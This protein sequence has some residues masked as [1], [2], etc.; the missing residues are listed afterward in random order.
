MIALSRIIRVGAVLTRAWGAHVER[1]RVESL[2]AARR[3]IHHHARARIVM[4]RRPEHSLIYDLEL[5]SLRDE[6]G[7]DH[8]REALALKEVDC[9]LFIPT[10]RTAGPPLP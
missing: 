4:S 3:D 1:P 8:R 10:L 2:L 7:L 6:L 5:T 9:P